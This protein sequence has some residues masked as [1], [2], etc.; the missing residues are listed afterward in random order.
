MTQ[1][2]YVNALREDKA[3][4]GIAREFAT[5]EQSSQQIGLNR[6]ISA[7]MAIGRAYAV[8]SNP[9]AGSNVARELSVT[10]TEIAETLQSLGAGKASTFQA[11][12]GLA[13]SLCGMTGRGKARAPRNQ[14]LHLASMAG[15]R[16]KVEKLVSGIGRTVADLRLALQGDAKGTQE[17]DPAK[18]D[19]ARAKRVEESLGAFHSPDAAIAAIIAGAKAADFL[20]ALKAA[21]KK[22]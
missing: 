4:A 11:Y 9:V 12:L 6:V 1:V 19:A 21:I 3:L 10:K 17:A 7:C 15:D 16:G 14:D 20:P 18:K 22:A 8:A 2:H 5:L 13:D